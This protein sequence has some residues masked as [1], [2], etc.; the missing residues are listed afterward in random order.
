MPGVKVKSTERFDFY[1]SAAP[2]MFG[3]TSYRPRGPRASRNVQLDDSP[4]E[5]VKASA[6][7][8]LPEPLEAPRAVVTDSKGRR[9]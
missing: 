2:S 7:A 1:E 6:R 3:I 5:M 4:W 8:T 9:L